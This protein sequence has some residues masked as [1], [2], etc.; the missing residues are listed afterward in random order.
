MEGTFAL[1]LRD[2][3]KK[4][5]QNYTR[6][7]QEDLGLGKPVHVSKVLLDEHKFLIKRQSP[8]MSLNNTFEGHNIAGAQLRSTHAIFSL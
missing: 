3:T 6:A 8:Y 5:L 7:Q 1:F 2:E 4:G